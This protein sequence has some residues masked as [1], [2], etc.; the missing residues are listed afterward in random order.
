MGKIIQLPI[1]VINK[2]AAGEIIERPANV[3]KE[4]VEN[5]IDAE[6]TEI[7]VEVEKAGKKRI[8]VADN[9][10]GMN[11]EDAILCVEKHTTSKIKNIEDIYKILSYG[12]RGEALASIASVSKFKLITSDGNESTKIIIENNIKKVSSD[13][14]NK[15]TKIIVEDLFFNI[16][17]RRKYL[18]SDNIELKHIIDTITNY[19]LVYPEISFK[20][21]ADNKVI[22]NA[23]K[24]NNLKDKVVL[25]LGLNYAKNSLEISYEENKIKVHGLIGN[26]NLVKKSKSDLYIFVNKRPVKSDVVE[27]AIK[28]AYGSYLSKE[29]FPFVVINIEIPPEAIDPNVHPK[30]ETIIF[31]EPEKVFSAVFS[32]IK[33]KLI[34]K[35]ENK[36]YYYEKSQKIEEKNSTLNNFEQPKEDQFTELRKIIES[37]KAEKKIS[38]EQEVQHL[39]QQKEE[40]INNTIKWPELLQLYYLGQFSNTYLIFTSSD[41]IWIFDQHLVEERYNYE[42][43]KREP[44]KVQQLLEPIILNINKKEFYSL[45]ESKE[46]LKKVG[47]EIEEIKDYFAIRSVPDLLKHLDS[48]EKEKTVKEIIEEFLELKRVSTIEILQDELLKTIACKSSVKAGQMLNPYSVKTMITNLAKCEQPYTCPHGRPVVIKI[49]KRELDKMFQRI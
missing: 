28:E 5:S 48:A 18:K 45:L 35:D 42:K 29:E 40:K 1:E 26:K 31:F 38:E 6:A 3:V 39:T 15:G 23:P 36:F 21:I 13:V 37:L 41:E 24:T 44:I 25:L 8:V 7:T 43:L 14:L 12:F 20:L 4:L 9:G 32:A 17:V 16:P 11:R 27:R 46:M 47:F 49:S 34:E 19:A 33:L 22:I 10:S 30:K 2:I